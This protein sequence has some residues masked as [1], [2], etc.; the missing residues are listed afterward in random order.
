MILLTEHFKRRQKQRGLKRDVL[1]F[2][3]E[4]G[5]IYFARKAEWVLVESKQL[6]GNIRNSSIAKRAAQW[7]ILM[8]DGSL[9]TCYRNDNPFRSV[10]RCN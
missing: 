9:L 7:V 6:P 10:A 1:N 8:E 2:I 5:K 3:L 4:Y